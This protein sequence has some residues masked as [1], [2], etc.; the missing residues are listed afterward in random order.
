VAAAADLFVAPGSDLHL[1]AAAVAIDSGVSL[2]SSFT[3]D[4]DGKLRPAGTQWDRGAHEFGATTAVKLESFTALA[5]DSSVLLEWRTA[6]ELSNLGFHLYRGPSLGGPWRR[7]TTSL[8]P[9][10]GSSPVGARYSYR[11]SGLENAVTYFYRL[12]DV[13]STGKTTFHGPVSATP[14]SG[15]ASNARETGSFI[16][17]GR[18]ERSGWRELSRSTSGVVLELTTEGFTAEPQEDGSV[19]LEIPGFEELE[20]DPSVPVLRPWIGVLSGRRA[21]I[22]RVEELSVDTISLRP[23]GSAELEVVASQRGSVRFRRG[24]VRGS[25]SIPG[26]VPLEAARLLQVGF[27]GDTKTAQLELAPLRWDGSRGKLSLAKRLRVHLSFRGR[28]VEGH[29]ERAAHRRREVAARLVTTQKGV[30]QIAYE[31]VVPGGRRGQEIPVDSL[32]LSRRGEAIAFH[33]E[34]NPL[35]FGPGSKLYFVSEGPEANPYGNELVYELEL[36][37]G[38]QM[39]RGEAAP[40][41]ENVAWY[42]KTT[43]YEENRLYQAGLL[44]ARDLWFWDV[45]LAPAAKSFPFAVSELAPGPS[46]LTVWLQGATQFAASPDHHLRLFVNGVLESELWWDGKEPR[47][48]ELPLPP[49]ALREGENVLRLENT[50]DTAAPYSMVMLDRFQVVFPRRLVAEGGKVEGSFSSSGTASVSGLGAAHL[51]DITEGAPRWLSGAVGSADG[52]F[53]FRAEAGRSYLAVS[54]NAVLSPRVQTV[55]AIRLRQENL[56]AEY[57]VV[58]PR[59]FST[60]AAPL[61][62]HRRSQGLRVKFAALEDVF[63]EFGFGEPRPEAIREFLSYAYHHWQSP[64][65][66]YVLLLG[67]ASYDFKDYLKTGVR[68]RVPPLMVKTSYLWTVS[69]PTYAAV[70]GDDLLPDVSIGRLPASSPGELRILVSK[71]LAYETGGVGLGG[72]LV[73]AA[74]NPDAA[75]NFPENAEEIARGVLAR[76]PVRRLYLHQL[77]AAMTAEILRAFEE[78]PSLISYLGHG[79]IHLWADENVFNTSHVAGLAPQPQQPLLLTLNC[80][81]GY[82]HFPYFDSLAEALLK[83]EGRGAIAAFSPSGLSLTAPAHRFHQLLLDALFLRGQERLGD[84]VL[85]AQREY[86]STG[87]FPELIS[88][89]HLLGDPALKLR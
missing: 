75:G 51:L 50:G 55:P 60:E 35:R 56:A 78:G 82:F 76:R 72:L 80:L 23:S 58:G 19:R 21:V 52:T 57:L 44:K 14:S 45:L 74:D 84:A 24:P 73:L 43:D 68:N 69:D 32:R 37:A 16:V 3:N 5:G 46:V 85:T 6:S 40:W 54:R 70:N 27:Q 67:D 71:I 86:A 12:E 2:A 61:L 26:L 39:D 81:N 1:K 53:R 31:A 15:A 38:R 48:V 59:E 33:V 66:R 11:D 22:T 28:V 34:P 62:D 36:G 49:G 29:R 65:L 30:H 63:S 10:L 64:R 13:E 18:P 88:I 77:G 79:G 7:L 47:T 20:G 25:G 17:Y 4:I 9:G 41:G 8:I 42:S 83:A 89:Y 87:A